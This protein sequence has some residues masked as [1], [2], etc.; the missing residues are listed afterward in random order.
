MKLINF[1]L[2]LVVIFL[3]LL[4]ILVGQGITVLSVIPSSGNMYQGLIILAGVI[5]A[6]MNYKAS[7]YGGLRY[8]R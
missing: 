6:I 3:G 7:S 2:G 4:P 5:I 1:I 8:R